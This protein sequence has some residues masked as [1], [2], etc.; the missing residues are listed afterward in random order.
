MTVCTGVGKWFHTLPS[1][2][3]FDEPQGLSSGTLTNTKLFSR[4]KVW[5]RR[6]HVHGSSHFVFQEVTL[7]IRLCSEQ[8]EMI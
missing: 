4:N 7:F 2:P 3:I 8:L 1:H 6:K 5:L